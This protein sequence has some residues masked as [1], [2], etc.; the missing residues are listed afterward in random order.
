MHDLDDLTLLRA[1][2]GVG[3]VALAEVFHLMSEALLSLLH[4]GEALGVHGSEDGE[5]VATVNVHA[6]SHRA[7]AVSG[8]NI[9][10]ILHV[11]VETP[12]E[13]VVRVALPVSIP[14]RIEVVA[15]SALTEDHLTEE[16]LLSQVQ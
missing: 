9:A 16:A 7:E 11:I 2:H 4:T 12:S 15:I 8:I 6:L 1:N 14:E 13:L 10:T 5:T 3:E